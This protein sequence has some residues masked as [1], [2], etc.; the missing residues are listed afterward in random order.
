[1]CSYMYMTLVN[2]YLFEQTTQMIKQ[3]TKDNNHF[4]KGTK[5]K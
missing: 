5:N 4:Q 3:Y 1:M 2:L